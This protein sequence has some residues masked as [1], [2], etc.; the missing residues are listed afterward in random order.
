MITPP[1]APDRVVCAAA[2]CAGTGVQDGNCPRHLTP[3]RLLVW[4]TGLGPSADVDLRGSRLPAELFTRIS[5]A[6]RDGSGVPRF[7]SLLFRAGWA[8]GGGVD[9][10]T[11]RF[12]GPV[13]FLEARFEGPVDFR[14]ARFEGPVNLSGSSFAGYADFDD[15]RF[16]GDLDASSLTA[17]DRFGFSRTE[18]GGRLALGGGSFGGRVSLTGGTYRGGVLPSGSRF[19]SG[20][21][22]SESTFEGDVDFSDLEVTGRFDVRDAECDGYA[23]FSG[24]TVSDGLL[25][26][27]GSRFRRLTDLGGLRAHQDVGVHDTVFHD[28][29]S[30]VSARFEGSLSGTAHILK[31]ID[32]D[33]AVFRAPAGLALCATRASFR[34]TRFEE[35]STITLR[36]AR[37]DLTDAVFLQPVAVTARAAPFGGRASDESA[38]RGLDPAVRV[39][40]LRGVDASLLSLAHTDLSECRFA[41]SFRLDQLHLEGRWTLASSPP[42]AWRRGVPLRRTHRQVIA[43]ER[44]WRSWPGRSASA[45]AGWGE[46]WHNPDETPGLATLT[47]VYRQLRKAREDAKDEPGAADLY[48][49]EMEM[50]RHSQSHRRAERWLLDAYWLLSGY[51]LRASRALGWLALAMIATIVLIMGFG[52]PDET[53]R[54][55]IRRV[56][57][58]GGTITVLHKSDPRLTKPFA[59]RFTG[60]RF[61]KALGITL[62]SVVFRTSGQDL[63]TTGGYVEMASRFTE[64]VLVGL[65]ALAIR[66]RVK[67]GA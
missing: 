14:G 40:S 66:G 13:D 38:F 27:S 53:P 65:A 47:T 16:A 4:L 15:A 64:P 11:A 7:G 49:G 17:M 48:Y 21:D 5:S 23:D 31:G 12:E 24:T 58:D 63:T 62:N 46:P 67:R 35:K 56:A 1:P 52:L 57:A 25:V 8:M 18:V 44:M 39:L 2:D 22:C 36:Y 32:F 59:E 41:G 51:G 61:D 60:K 43:E 33:R 10:R 50:R 55:E 19:D 30:F 26:L 42:G 34:G 20:L 29:V 9:L 37:V 28:E 6:V 3:D 54:Q 45:R